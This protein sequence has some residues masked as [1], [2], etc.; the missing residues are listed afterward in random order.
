MTDFFAMLS[1]NA[2]VAIVGGPGAGKTSL[3]E[4]VD[5]RPVFHTDD[6]MTGSWESQPHLWLERTRTLDRFVIEGVQ[7][8]RYLRKAAQLGEPCPVDAVVYLH[9]AKKVL[10]P[11][12][13]GLAKAV[14]KVF[15]D[16]RQVS[17][18]TPVLDIW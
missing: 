13:S 8:A 14:N 18:Q 11:R 2:R 5:D 17:A 10:T 4:A 3:V 1:E 6:T 16:W 7:T 9:G 15:N 12:Q